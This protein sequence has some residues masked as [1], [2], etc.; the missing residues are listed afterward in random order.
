MSIRKQIEALQTKRNGHLDAM[1]ALSTLAA[2]DNR[3]FTAD[4]QAAWDKDQAEVRDIDQSLSRLTEYERQLAGR[5]QPAPSPTGLVEVRAKFVPFKGQAFT[6][7]IGALAR[8]KGNLM[9]AAELA[10]AW[11][12]ETPEVGEVLR[13]AVAA[14]TTTDPAWAGPLV[15]YQ[16]MA[17]EFV[18]L[19]RAQTVLGRLSGYRTVPFL[20]KIPRQTAGATAGW[21]GEGASKP[22]TAEAFDQLTVPWAKMA[23]ICVITQELAR[24]SNPA[25]E[26]L[27]RDD[28]LKAIAE[29]M[30]KQLT[31]DTVT[32]LAGIRPASITNGATK[33]PSSGGTVGAVTTDL[34]KAILNI[35]A[36]NIP[37]LRPVWLM[38]YGVATYLATLRTSTDIFAFPS[39]AAGAAP[40]ALGIAPSLM[41]I[42]VV[43]SGN[44]KSGVIILLEQS[45]LMV[46]DDGQT[47]IDTSQEAAL[48][49][50]SAP[51][52]PPTPLVSLW[53]Q[54]LLGIKAERYVYWL[55]R[56]TAAVQEI[57]GAAIPTSAEAGPQPE[58][59]PATRAKQHA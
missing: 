1:E 24:F 6:R 34:S 44:I 49:L 40:G 58:P 29:F 47:M 52:T 31:D 35:T 17:S 51:A 20:V 10:K 22:V 27:V 43:V 42:P 57:T 12:H 2:N 15:N 37:L 16:I 18:E 41:G 5:A 33:I 50:D 8:S 55:M 9:L 30:D 13:A 38:G 11:E 39:M 21:V 48:Q 26:Q 36:A 25:A 23:V 53:Q 32:A 59:P 46:A 7:Y 56:R 3:V 4:E 54:N 14:G 28:L 19:L 45:E